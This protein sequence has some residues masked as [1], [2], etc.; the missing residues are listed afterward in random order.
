VTD[1]V[2]IYFMAGGKVIGFPRLGK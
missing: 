1:E 2:Q